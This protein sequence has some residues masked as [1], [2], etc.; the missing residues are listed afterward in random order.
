MGRRHCCI[1]WHIIKKKKKKKEGMMM[2]MY[3]GYESIKRFLSS[4]LI[5]L[6]SL[7]KVHDACS[8]CLYDCI[9]LPICCHWLWSGLLSGGGGGGENLWCLDSW[10]PEVGE[11]P[12]DMD[13][14]ME[15]TSMVVWFLRQVGFHRSAPVWTLICV[16]I[17]DHIAIGGV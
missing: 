2:F 4:L 6:A 12:L 11:P 3:M 7:V 16:P 10:N 14:S 17:F 15:Q 1:P 5:L 8:K 13:F 9:I